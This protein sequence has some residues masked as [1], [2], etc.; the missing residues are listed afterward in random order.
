MKKKTNITSKNIIKFV[1]F[2]K[3]NKLKK[4]IKKNG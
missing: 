3:K 4:L 1:Y 2:F